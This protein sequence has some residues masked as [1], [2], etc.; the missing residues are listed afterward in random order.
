[1]NRKFVP[2]ASS[3]NSRGPILRVGYL[4]QS[5]MVNRHILNVANTFYGFG[6]LLGIPSL[7]GTLYFGFA[8]LRLYLAT[9]VPRAPQGSSAQNSGLDLLDMAIRATGAVFGFI[10]AVGDAVV[11]GLAVASVAI[12]LLSLTLLFTSRGLHAH[13]GWAR[14]VA[15]LVLTFLLLVALLALLSSGSKSLIALLLASGSCYGLW[16]LWR[17]FA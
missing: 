5:L 3:P 12:L 9:P 2:S 1:M 7:A 14:L 17:G 6:L 8:A 15:G 10:G 13:A 4:G 11:R 16:A